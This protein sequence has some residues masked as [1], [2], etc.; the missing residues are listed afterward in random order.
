M[1]PDAATPAQTRCAGPDCANPIVRRHRR[2]RPPLYC[3]PA[4]RRRAA[5]VYVDID[6]DPDLPGRPAGRVWRVRLRRQQHCVVIVDG[7]GR[8]CAEDLAGKITTLLTPRQGQ[9]PL[10]RPHQ[11][12]DPR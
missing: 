12:R 6:C 9:H 1:T 4:C 10:T 5:R 7:L 3:S 8:L 11:P 2:G